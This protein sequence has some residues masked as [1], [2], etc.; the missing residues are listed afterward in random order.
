MK[1]AGRGPGS[2][3]TGVGVARPF[4]AVAALALATSGCDDLIKWVP[5]FSTMS[6]QPSVETYEE[7]PRPPVEGTIAID[8]EYL[9]AV[10]EDGRLVQTL[11]LQQADTLS[12][13]AAWQPD[14]ERGET[15]YLQF[16][17]PCHGVAGMGDGPVVGPNR[18][19]EVP[20]LNL[21]SEQARAYS[22]G[23]IWGMITIGRG[24]MPSYRRI[25]PL[26]RWDIVAYVQALQEGSTTAGAAGGRTDAGAAEAATEE[27]G[28]APDPDTTGGGP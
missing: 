10:A 27:G 21:R 11:T 23:Y 18:I 14:L 9:Y 24:I 8:G 2:F 7:Q 28:D 22:D 15:R 26:E 19:P 12:P 13:P 3:R 1:A 17:A 25:P 16:C 4:A 6:E 5:I 20:M